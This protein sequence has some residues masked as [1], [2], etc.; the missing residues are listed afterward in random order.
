MEISYLRRHLERHAAPLHRPEPA[1]SAVILPF[2]QTK[3]RAD[4]AFE[5]YPCTRMHGAAFETEFQRENDG[6]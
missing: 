2:P 6:I 1:K 4:T 3:P 5:R